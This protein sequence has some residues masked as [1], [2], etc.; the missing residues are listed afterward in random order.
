[1]DMSAPDGYFEG[2]N[3]KLL[4]AVPPDARQV[5]EF[6]CASGRLGQAYKRI[7][8]QV[9]W[10]GVDLAG[11]AIQR[12]G[13]RLDRVIQMDL[14]GPHGCELDAQY[15]VIVIGDLIEHL[16]HPEAL[17]AFAH[18]LA[19]EGSRLVCCIP[20][21]AHVS[22]IERMLAGDLSY[23]KMGLLDQTHVRFLSLASSYKMLLDAG[24]MPNLRDSYPVGHCNQ[25]LIQSL[26]EASRQIG[27]PLDTATRNLLT[28]QFI[29]DCIKAPGGASQSPPAPFSVIVPVNNPQQ[30]DLNV[31]RSPGLA[32]VGAELIRIEGACSAADALQRGR[33]QARYDWIVLCHQDVYFPSGSGWALAAGLGAVPR[34][35][36]SR[37]LI[38]FAGLCIGSAGELQ[39][40]G[41]VIDRAAR[42]DA[43]ES[44][45]AVSID[46][47]AVALSRN[48]IHRIDPLLGWHLWA[49]DLCLN[50]ILRTRS[51][52]AQ[53]MRVPL[54]HNSYNDGKLTADFHRSADILV[55]KYPELAMIPTLCGTI[56]QQAPKGAIAV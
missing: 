5:L 31:A 26:A 33:Q 37:A 49:T 45:R 20:N 53:V 2:L 23:D 34:E 6:G 40:T 25:S 16:R 41:L 17:L 8:P 9:L 48:T 10:T 22:V 15:D 55:R 21:M 52:H 39:K 38:G 51:G 54:F 18:R 19:T 11:P 50:S 47:L 14:D 35:Q 27:I 7:N 43:P 42:F 24:W 29:I 12:A 46:E 36:V 3:Q 44:D 28:Y 4:A 13:Q 30:F 56:A 1:M 32:E